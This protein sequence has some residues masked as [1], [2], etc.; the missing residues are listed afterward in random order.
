M[1]NNII[2]K[3]RQE[4]H[5]ETNE[6]IDFRRVTYEMPDGKVYD[7]YYTYSVR[8]YVVIVPFDEEGCLITVRQYRQGIREITNEF[9]AGGMEHIARPANGTQGG[10][11]ENW[12]PVAHGM[13]AV[14]NGDPTSLY[15]PH[16]DPLAAAK[17]ELLEESGYTSDEWTHLIT[18]PSNATRADNYAVIYMA[19][20]CRKASAQHLD[21]TEFLNVNLKTSDEIEALIKNGEFQQAIHVLAWELAKQHI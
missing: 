7:N 3:L 12:D 2:W 10:E 8:S 5:I 9:P 1:E 20:N 15:A 11:E 4:D 14:G 13:K 21:E 19:K 18:V 6:Y 16:E 17:R